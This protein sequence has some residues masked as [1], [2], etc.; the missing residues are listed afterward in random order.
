MKLEQL[1]KEFILE[2]QIKDYS[3]RTIKSYNNNNLL[4]F[5]FLFKE[6]D[7][8]QVEDVK[9]PHIKAYIKYLQHNKRKTSY[10]NGLIR[11]FRAYF[12]YATEEEIININPMLRVGWVKGEKILINTFTNQEVS[13]MMEVYKGSDYMNIRNKTIMATLFDTGIRNFELCNIKNCD[14]KN[15]YINV[16]QGKG[17]KDR[18]VSLSPYLRKLLIRYERCR[19]SYFQNRIIDTDTSYFLSYRFKPLTIEAVERIVKLCGEG[20]K[21]RKEI[22]CSP[23]TCRHYFAQAQLR[24]GLD[25][26]SLSR[27]LGHEDISITK[28][29]LQ[30]INDEDIIEMSV[31]TS[32]LMNLKKNI[33]NSKT[34]RV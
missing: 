6:F 20:A 30:G 17:R 9:P 32:P 23:H 27:L 22:R 28:K 21:I 14:V 3:K 4:L 11:V 2:L 13:K 25:V 31:K 26:Y 5:T 15:N 7:I 10:I 24:N 29:Y 18:R 16:I 33:Q 12:K 19:D 8:T 34:E 1:L